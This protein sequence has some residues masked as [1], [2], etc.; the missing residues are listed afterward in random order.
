MKP[1]LRDNYRYVAVRIISKTQIT[2][3]DLERIVQKELPSIMGQIHYSGVMP[4]IV[5]F[6]GFKQ[7]AIFRCLHTGSDLLKSSLSLISSYNSEKI[8][9][10]P[11]YTS[12]TIRKAKE[13]MKKSE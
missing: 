10:M 7:A 11:V 12:G 1:T 3:D 4:K 8:H 5:F 2:K 6:D 9:L 13:A